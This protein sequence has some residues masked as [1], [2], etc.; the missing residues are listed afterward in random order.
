MSV[1]RKE[2]QSSKL[3]M[4]NVFTNKAMR[5]LFIAFAGSLIGDGVFSLSA[6]VYAFRSGGASA[7]GILAIVRYLAIATASP[8]T[9]TFADQYDRKKVMVVSDLLRLVLVSLAAVVVALDGSKWIVYA[10]VVAVG[11]AGTAFRPAQGS[12]LPFLARRSDEMSGANVVASTIESVGFFAGPALAGFL[13]AFANV[14]IS[15]AFDAATFVWSLL[16]VTSI[17]MPR[18]EE[19]SVEFAAQFDNGGES[20]AM[21]SQ[22]FIYR[23]IQGFQLIKGDKDVRTLVLL[24]ILQCIVAGASAVFTV[25]IALQ[26]LHIGSSGLGLMESLLGIGGL[27]GGFVALILVERAHLAIDFALGVIVWAA[28]LILIAIFPSLFASL[29]SMWL[30]GL[31]NSVVDVNAITIL[32]HIVPN[33]KLGRV[34]GA[35]EAGTIAG[36]AVGSLLMTLFIHWLG[37]RI[38]LAVIG[39][40]ITL[41]VLPG[42]PT[43]K[44]IDRTAFVEGVLESAR[45]G[46]QTHR[47]HLHHLRR[48]HPH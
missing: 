29:L 7:V 33:E 44:R 1:I 40:S 28:P 26:L 34:L 10:L 22:S 46:H 9:S 43:M 39:G 21:K 13:L 32:Q 37:L 6:I 11:V 12:I 48:R 25:A 45:G 19:R 4:T 20:A 18:P 5:R 30:I 24:Y 14:S 27:V 36:M 2:I 47:L 17:R 41:A 8:I 15:F 31:A 35:L 23:A 38:G 3:A 16:F 42:L